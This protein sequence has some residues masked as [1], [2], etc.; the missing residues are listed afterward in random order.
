MLNPIFRADLQ[1]QVPH[2]SG[3]AKGSQLREF[4]EPHQQPRKMTGGTF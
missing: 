1:R 4:D 2:D 3:C